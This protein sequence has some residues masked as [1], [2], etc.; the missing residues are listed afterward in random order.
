MKSDFYDNVRIKFL[1]E[2]QFK[3]RQIFV[4]STTRCNSKCNTCNIYNKEDENISLDAIRTIIN[5]VSNRKDCIIYFEGGEF[6]LHPQYDKILEMAQD[7]DY[8]IISNGQ[9]TEKIINSVLKFNI[10]KIAFSLDGPKETYK[11]VRGIDGFDN[12]MNTIESVKSK[13]EIHINSTINPWNTYEDIKWVKEFCDKNNFMWAIQPMYPINF[14]DNDDKNFSEYIFDV[15]D[16]LHNSSFISN[17]NNY[18]CGKVYLPCLNVRETIVVYPNGNIP[19]CHMRDEIVLGNLYEHSLEDIITDNKIIE[20]QK[21]S[22]GCN[23]CWLNCQ[24]MLDVKLFEFMESKYIHD[25]L[26]EEFGKYKWPL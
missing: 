14:F 3:L 16:L 7:V 20:L 11:N 6:F 26:E 5:F 19:L 21:Q 25:K 13:T 1:E 4:Y 10:K 17:T 15:S 18:F 12:L 2:T 24:R 23:K 22:L 8:C 9:F